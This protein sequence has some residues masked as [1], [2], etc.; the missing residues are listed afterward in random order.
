MD[1]MVF[2]IGEV[3]TDENDVSGSIQELS[4]KLIVTNEL[5]N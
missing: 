1:R 4:S 5:W 3:T 2:K